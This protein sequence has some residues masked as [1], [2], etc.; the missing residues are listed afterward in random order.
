MPALGPSIKVFTTSRINTFGGFNV[1]DSE[2][3]HPQQ[4]LRLS[5]SAA[6]SDGGA[7]AAEI[8]QFVVTQFG[9]VIQGEIVQPAQ[10]PPIELECRH[11]LKVCLALYL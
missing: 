10:P 8:R 7:K 4:N 3:V 5:L 6:P 2:V 11:L 1:L 9:S